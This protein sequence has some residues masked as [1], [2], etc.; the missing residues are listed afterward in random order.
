MEPFDSLP[1]GVDLT[2][3]ISFTAHGKRLYR[4]SDPTSLILYSGT[5]PVED[6][7]PHA[8]KQPKNVA[9]K[10]PGSYIE[11]VVAEKGTAAKLLDKLKGRADGTEPIVEPDID[12]TP[13]G[14]PLP[15]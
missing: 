7:I 9:P 3:R 6:L 15:S 4:I 8:P 12:T 11:P 14:D 5:I 2:L 10:S 13:T 1:T